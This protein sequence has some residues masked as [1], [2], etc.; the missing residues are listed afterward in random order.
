MIILVH[1]KKIDDEKRMDCIVIDCNCFLTRLLDES[2]T[3][4]AG[5]QSLMLS[6]LWTRGGVLSFLFMPLFFIIEKLVK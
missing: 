2:K 3:I 5:R 4:C 1:Q 6:I